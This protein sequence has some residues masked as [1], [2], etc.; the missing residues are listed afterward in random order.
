MELLAKGG[1]VMDND[2]QTIAAIAA[3]NHITPKALFDTIKPAVPA[4]ESTVIPFPDE[5]V[6]GFGKRILSQ[7]CAEY[8]LQPAL[9]IEGLAKKNISARPEQ[10]I[11]E[12]AQATD[13]DPHSFFSLLRQVAIDQNN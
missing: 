12:I 13:M 11:R 6:P 5:P 10:T 1:L 3:R 8:N 9:I 7:L 4:M 2:Q